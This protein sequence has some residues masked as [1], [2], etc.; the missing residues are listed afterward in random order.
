M[1]GYITR[2]ANGS[3]LMSAFRPLWTQVRGTDHH[4]AYIRPGD[5]VGTRH[6]CVESMALL[7][8]EQV[9]A[10]QPGQTF[11]AELSGRIMGPIE[12]IEEC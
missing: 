9:L 2:Q 7:F 6:H 1:R 11:R 3:F 12:A 10:M 5:P 8:G 4:D